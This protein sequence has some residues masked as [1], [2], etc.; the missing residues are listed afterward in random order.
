MDDL[1]AAL[2]G[3][4][5]GDPLPGA[6][7]PW[8]YGPMPALREGPPWAMAEMIAAEPA[9]GER[10][11]R[12]LVADGTAA[13]LAGAV[14]AA[15]EAGAPVVV[16][17]CGT[18]EHGGEAVGGDPPRRAGA[19]RASQGRRAAVAV[20]A[21][22]LALDPPPRAASSSG[23]ATRAATAA[24]I[25]ALDGGPGQGRP[26]GADHRVGGVA[27][28]RRRPTSS[29]RPGSS[30]RAGATRSATSRRSRP[31]TV[32]VGILAGHAEP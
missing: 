8:D 11:G 18:S 25:A 17:G 29:S 1:L 23:S 30:T 26:H 22:E 28:R 5:P 3:F 13:A 7:E 6:P 2:P 14:R 27:R 16:T 12:R 20:Q 24:T 4:R 19:P 9:L 32:A 15:A 21:F 10:V 31:A